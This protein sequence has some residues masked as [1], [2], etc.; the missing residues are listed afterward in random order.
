MRPALRASAAIALAGALAG[1]AGERGPVEPRAPYR[2]DRRDYAT[3]QAGHP[4]ILEPNYLPFAVHRIPGDGRDGDALVFC[5]WSRDEMPLPVYIGAPEIP[6]E[7][8]DEFSPKE[9]SAYVAAVEAAL[10]M[11]QRDLEG[12]VSFR[13]VAERAESKL[14]LMLIAGR[15]PT[16]DPGLAVL[17]TVPVAGACVARGPVSGRLELDV[18]FSVPQAKLYIVDEFGLLGAEQVQWIALHEIGHALGVRAHSP[19]PADLMYEVVR[20]RILVSELSTE[21]VNTYVSLYELENGTVFR[22]LPPDDDGPA[23][24]A[25]IPPASGPPKL[26]MAPFVDA[27]HGFQVHPPAGWMRIETAR[28]MVAVDGL[29]WDYSASFQ[30]IVERYDTIEAYLDR[31]GAYYLSKGRVLGWEFTEVSGFRTL[32]ASVVDHG[33]TASEQFLF[34]EVGDGRLVIVVMDCAVE[35]S[36]AYVP[37]F[38]AALASL[39]I[40]RAPSQADASPSGSPAEAPQ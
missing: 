8:Q 31:F 38:Q 7:I 32:R 18:R 30:V 23:D 35:D 2:P 9:P 14:A 34:I 24:P 10:A 39:E 22:H 26:A 12:L 36:S 40:W 16:Q 27:R 1:C 4:G 6:D 15:G 33:D 29:T 28:G 13:R 17:G 37:W 3:F 20:D 11:W 5:R 25:A 19:I 21:D